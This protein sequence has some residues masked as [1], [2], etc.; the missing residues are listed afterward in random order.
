MFKNYFSGITCCIAILIIVSSCPSF[1][2]HILGG[3]FTYKFL[4]DTSISGTPHKIY[5][6]TLQQFRDC[7]AL[8]GAL[9][10]DYHVAITIFKGAGPDTISTKTITFDNLETYSKSLHIISD[11]GWTPSPTASATCLSTLT[12][13]RIYYLPVSPDGYTIVNQRCCRNNGISNII[14]SG[15]R[16]ITFSCFIP[17]DTNSANN[18]AVFPQYIP[19]AFCVNKAVSFSYAASDP[20]GDSL[21]Y[22]LTPLLTYEA[23][24]NNISPR[25]AFPPPFPTVPFAPGYGS[26]APMGNSSTFSI[27]PTNGQATITP[28]T[29]GNYAVGI[30]CK[31]WRNG[32]LINETRRELEWAVFSCPNEPTDYKP[33]AGKDIRTVKGTS[34]QL[35]A[36]GAKTYSWSPTTHLD[37]PDSCCPT[38]KL[39]N[40]GTF[41]YILHGISDSGCS[42]YDTLN[43]EVLNNSELAIPNAFTPNNDGVNDYFL[44]KALGNAYVTNF[45]VFNKWGNLLYDV[46]PANG[47][48]SWDGKWNEELQPPGVYVYLIEYT[49]N[50]GVMHKVTGTITLLK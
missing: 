49:D 13:S 14:K 25:V 30:V 38:A 43:I 15:V 26:T 4:G 36:S 11:C 39:S 31:E 17:C 44:P 46:H 47:R 29:Q 35:V 16:G 22:E 41:T 50:I 12:F 3:G 20:D 6:V 48:A 7:N 33:F 28:L 18:S 45:R 8:E 37:Y 34:I 32:M 10:E 40:E 2:S 19:Q 1:A 23:E 42:G 5:Q 24:E 27:N 9:K 21:T